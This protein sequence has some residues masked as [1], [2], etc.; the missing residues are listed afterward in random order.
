MFAPGRLSL[1]ILM[2]V[3]EPMNGAPDAG[4]E[5]NHKH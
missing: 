4:F 3:G 5:L 2:F 1:P